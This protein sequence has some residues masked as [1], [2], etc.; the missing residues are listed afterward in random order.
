MKNVLITGASRGIGKVTKEIFEQQGYNVIAPTRKEMDL[1]NNDSI[2]KYCTSLKDVS[3]FSIINNAGINNINLLEKVSLKEI[4]SMLQVDLEAPILILQQLIPNLKKNNNARIV[5]I[6]SIWAVVSKSGRA[7][8][9]AAKNGIHGI[10][11]ALAVELGE[12][13]I[14]INTVCPGFTL[15]DLT[16]K[17]NSVEEIQ[18]ISNDIPLKRMANPIEIAK[19]IYFLGSEE[20]TYITGQKIVID[21]GFSIK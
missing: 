7:L 16:Y 13:G 15:T 20:N 10:T 12:N 21:G 9:S 8:Y 2:I 4:D 17:N 5:N 14:L 1:N 3:L 18:K 19:L 11:N 6:G